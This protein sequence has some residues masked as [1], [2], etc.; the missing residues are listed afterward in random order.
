VSFRGEIGRRRPRI[1]RPGEL[2]HEREYD[3]RVDHVP[4]T[5]Q[6][7]EPTVSLERDIEASNAELGFGTGF[8]R[9]SLAD[10]ASRVSLFVLVLVVYSTALLHYTAGHL[11]EFPFI[12]PGALRLQIQ[13]S[14]VS[15]AAWLA[16]ALT[17]W[18][19]RR[20]GPESNFFAHAPIQLFAVTNAMFGYMLGLITTPYGYVVLIGGILVSLPL[21]GRGPTLL[22]IATWTAMSAALIVLEQS[23]VISYAP[24]LRDS[25]IVAGHLSTAWLLGISSITVTAT[26]LTAVF[27]FYMIR[28]LRQR[29]A[30]LNSSQRT[31]LATV[32]DLNRSTAEL[33]RSRED[34]ES[35]VEERTREIEI[36]NQNLRLQVQE[37]EKA[38][39]QLSGIKAAMEAAVEGMA[40]VSGDGNFETVNA[41]FASM[42]ESTASAMLGTAADDWLDPKDRPALREAVLELSSGEKRE[43]GTTGLRPN[44]RT[45]PQSLALVGAL[46]GAPREHYR[47]ARDLTD[48]QEMT[49]QL[50][51]AMK[52]EAI[53]HLAGSIAHDFNNF[54]LAIL[55]SAEELESHSREAPESKELSNL[56]HLI[57]LAGT[58]AADL[59]RQLLDFAQGRPANINPI[60]I[61]ESLEN[62]IQ[63]VGSALRPSIRVSREFADGALFTEGDVSRFESGLVNIALNARDAMP[64]GGK[65]RL[66]TQVERVEPDDPRFAGFDLQGELFIRIDSIDNGSGL[67]AGTLDRIL[68]PF[69]TTKAVGEG[70]GLGLSVF[71]SY[72]RDIGGAIRFASTVGTGTT[73]SIYAPLLERIPSR[74]SPYSPQT[75]AA[76]GEKILLA[77]DDPAVMRALTLLLTRNGYSVLPCSNGLEAVETFRENRDT[78]QAALIDFRMPVMNGAD[79][80]TEI[81]KI[82]PSFPVILMSGNL[83][84]P[85]LDALKKEGLSAVLEKPYSQAVLMDT[86]RRALVDSS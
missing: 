84:D 40:R 75:E 16:I 80:F 77:E 46:E 58:R 85:A 56:A 70:T 18:A 81:N 30:R 83:A 41:A 8:L 39:R 59:T 11:E 68:D 9:W 35:R 27:A 49:A 14:Y 50:N 45:F 22:G 73:C 1:S 26:L 48:Q 54:L 62:S 43:L 53:G 12:D 64:D 47:F 38:A 21:F 28:Q 32:Q 76:D 37:R 24:L 86:I 78:V 4:G 17:G 2:R 25:P 55:A 13:L 61:H 57:T 23:G 79:A 74:T 60:D 7:R 20:R 15:M 69:F 72:I 19:L 44:G 5:A 51:Q 34:L 63:L 6:P 33:E 71:S 82:D 67:D 10:K 66:R 42:H 31:L 65:L 3:P 52:M 29:D 36:A